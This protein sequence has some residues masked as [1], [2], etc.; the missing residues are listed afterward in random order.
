VRGMKRHG[1]RVLVEGRIP[2]RCEVEASG[3]PLLRRSQKFAGSEGLY[4]QALQVERQSVVRIRD[5][6]S[7]K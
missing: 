4:K 5:G 2:G 1:K 6:L 7:R 3:V